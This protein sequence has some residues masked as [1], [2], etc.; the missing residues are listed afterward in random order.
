VAPGPAFSAS[1]YFRNDLRI[2]AGYRWSERTR[3]ALDL[4]AGMIRDQI[5]R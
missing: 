1:G 2:N 5:A 3:D 4:V